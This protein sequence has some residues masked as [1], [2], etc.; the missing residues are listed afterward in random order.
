MYPSFKN[1][2]CRKLHIK[3][4]LLLEFFNMQNNHF[5]M[6]VNSSEIF[7]RNFAKLNQGI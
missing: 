6:L 4:F 7:F 5:F 3:I 1:F 2:P